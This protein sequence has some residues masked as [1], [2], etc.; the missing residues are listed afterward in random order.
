MAVHGMDGASLLDRAR[1]LAPAACRQPETFRRAAC[2]ILR[3]DLAVLSKRGEPEADPR[4]LVKALP[5]RPLPAP[6]LTPVSKAVIADLLDFLVQA[7]PDTTCSGAEEGGRV[8]GEALAA[9]VAV[10]PEPAELPTSVASILASGRAAPGGRQPGDAYDDESDEFQDLED[11]FFRIPGAGTAGGA[12]RENDNV[13][14]HINDDPL[15]ED[16]AISLPLWGDMARAEGAAAGLQVVRHK[17]DLQHLQIRFAGRGRGGRRAWGRGAPPPPAGGAGDGPPGCG[18]GGAGRGALPHQAARL[19]VTGG[20]VHCMAPVTTPPSP[21]GTS[22]ST[23]GT[24]ARRPAPP[25][26]SSPS[27]DTTPGATSCI[28]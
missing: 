27:S 18:R 26:S 7:D 5:G 9:A 22:S 4:L 10:E 25:P 28:L 2:D 21:V 11:A 20:G 6:P 19:Q 17:Y 13:I 15:L 14:G 23:P 8:D 12:D 24:A 3:V 16:R 1:S